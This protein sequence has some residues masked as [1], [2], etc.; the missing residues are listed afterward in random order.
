MKYRLDT[1]QFSG[2][3]SCFIKLSRKLILFWKA[4]TFSKSEN[5]LKQSQ[6]KLAKFLY[7][8]H[9]NLLFKPRY[10]SLNKSLKVVP[11]TVIHSRAASQSCTGNKFGL[12]AK[13]YKSARSL[14]HE[15]DA[16]VGEVG[17]RKRAWVQN[18][19]EQIT[20]R[21]ISTQ[22]LRQFKHIKRLIADFESYFSIIF[23][24]QHS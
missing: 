2:R 12:Y 3:K 21:K 16:Y 8:S 11:N 5:C 1:V 17:K 20:S 24:A 19:H 6:K 14:H 13:P 10:L 9:N 22:L 7:K 4:G 23:S 15:I 18:I